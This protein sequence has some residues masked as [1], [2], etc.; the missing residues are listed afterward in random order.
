[1]ATHSVEFQQRA[2]A[3]ICAWEEGVN[4]RPFDRPQGERI[5]DSG[6]TAVRPY[7]RMDSI[8]RDCFAVLAMA[9]PPHPD[10]L[11]GNRGEGESF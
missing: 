11:L 8:N 6:R 10:P 1:M 3:I 4:L 7:I 9:A 5:S 2:V